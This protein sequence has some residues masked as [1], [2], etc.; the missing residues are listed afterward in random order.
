MNDRPI[1]YWYR[2]PVVPNSPKL[3]MHL[4]RKNNQMTHNFTK[5]SHIVILLNLMRHI[6]SCFGKAPQIVLQ[7]LKAQPA[8]S[9]QYPI[10]SNI[11][12]IKLPMQK[13]QPCTCIVKSTQPLRPRTKKKSEAKNRLF[14]DRPSQG[15]GQEWLRQRRR[16][17]DT[18]F[19]NCLRTEN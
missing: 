3:T 2:R 7:C 19:L 16:T 9:V 10:S 12:F 11:L 8:F 1:E 13:N 14:E 5:V 15:Q 4:S 6:S 17:E 18:I